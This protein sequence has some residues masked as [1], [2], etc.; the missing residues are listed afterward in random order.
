MST[1]SFSTRRPLAAPTRINLRLPRVSVQAMRAW[2][3][4]PARRKPTP[5]AGHMYGLLLRPAD[6]QDIERRA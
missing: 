2:L 3:D 1:D 5:I 6:R 4:E